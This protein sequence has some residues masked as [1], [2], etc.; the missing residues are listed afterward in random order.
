[1]PLLVS[2]IYLGY[3][4]G[5]VCL[6]SLKYFSTINKNEWIL[7]YIRELILKFVLFFLFYF[8]HILFSISCSLLSICPCFVLRLTQK[9][10]LS[11]TERRE[12]Q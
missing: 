6:I 2:L 12:N 9:R 4:F 7:Y 8:S 10:L 5:D 1:M 3:M 11:N